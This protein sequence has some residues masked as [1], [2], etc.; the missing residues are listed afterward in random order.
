M[1]VVD[2][3]RVLPLDWLSQELRPTS[4]LSPH[5][6]VRQASHPNFH[7]LGFRASPKFPLSRQ[8]MRLVS[9][10]VPFLPAATLT[11]YFA[12][13]TT[14]T[15]ELRMVDTSSSR[16][17]HFVSVVQSFVVHRDLCFLTGT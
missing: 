10:S 12:W 11:S 15:F 3:E 17:S 9:S 5:S 8:S 2:D 13:W 14:S 4:L 7:L 16:S 6:A 1:V